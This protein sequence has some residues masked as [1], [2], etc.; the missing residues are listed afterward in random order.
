MIIF[1]ANIDQNID[2][3]LSSQFLE[4]ANWNSPEAIMWMGNMTLRMEQ[5]RLHLQRNCEFFGLNIPGND[6]LHR[7]NAWEFLINRPRHLVWC[8]VFKAASTSWMYNFNILAGYSSQFLQKTKEVPLQLARRRY[9]RP[10]LEQLQSA[11]N[12]S[13]A[14]LIVRHPLERLL[15]G[16]RDKIK[17][18]LPHTYHQKL[19]NYIITKYRPGASTEKNARKSLQEKNLGL[20]QKRPTFP[21]FVQFLVDLHKSGKQFDMHWAPITEFCTPCQ[22]RFDVI[23]KFET[24]QDDQNYLIQSLKLHKWIKPQWKN[25]SKGKSKTSNLIEQYYSQLT[26]S[27]IQ[28]LYEIYRYDFHLFGYTLD[29]YLQYG[30]ESEK[31]Q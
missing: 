22:V 2:G 5:R 15:S 26:K 25:P 10:S 7:P 17:F 27:Q 14:F 3:D 4:Y 16:Y 18:A 30:I 28:Q 19:G 21:E 11:L 20:K 6:T 24:L 29:E 13:V 31:T 9:P 12:D 23:M 1:L 8:N